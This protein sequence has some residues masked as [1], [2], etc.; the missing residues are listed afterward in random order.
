MLPSITSRLVLCGTQ[1]APWH[2]CFVARLR[3]AFVAMLKLQTCGVCMFAG[4]GAPV[5]Q[6]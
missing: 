4:S 5:V 2:K 1:G 6:D 3:I